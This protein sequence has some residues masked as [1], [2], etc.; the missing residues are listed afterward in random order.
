[1][2]G[3]QEFGWGMISLKSILDIQVEVWSRQMDL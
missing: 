3:T 2:G 1:M